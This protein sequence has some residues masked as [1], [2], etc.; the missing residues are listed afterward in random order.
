MT[1]RHMLHVLSLSALLWTA[2]AVPSAASGHPEAFE[3]E[4]NGPHGDCPIVWQTVAPG[5]SYR[6]ISCLGDE[7]DIDVHAVRIDPDIWQFDTVILPPTRALEAARQFSVPFSITA[8]VFDKAHQPEGLLVRSGVEVQ[9]ARKVDWQGVFLMTQEGQPKILPLSNWPSYRNRTYMAVQSGPR[10]VI[11]GKR[12]TKIF[13]SYPA[14]RSGVCLQR[15]GSLIFFV[16]PS[17]RKF[18]MNEIAKVASRREDDGGLECYEALLFDGGHS[19]Q[20]YVGG[21][22]ERLSTIADPVPAFIVGRPKPH[23]TAIAPSP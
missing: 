14:A 7:T 2:A 11:A 10:V 13:K 12:N 17:E 22:H 1:S 18:D 19:T 3:K 8:G 9:P 5:L 21:L 4:K 20:M 6:K 23:D 15:S 16:T